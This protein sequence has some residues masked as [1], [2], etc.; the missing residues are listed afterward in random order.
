MEIGVANGHGEVE[1][2]LFDCFLILRVD[3]GGVCIYDCNGGHVR[4]EVVKKAK[5]DA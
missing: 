1:D 2:G 3:C 5:G 4:E